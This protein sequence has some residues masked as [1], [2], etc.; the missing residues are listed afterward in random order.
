LAPKAAAELV[1]G[2]VIV[3][4]VFAHVSIGQSYTSVETV[5]QQ[6]PAQTAEPIQREQR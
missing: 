4:A 2:T 5:Q 3:I 1:A 6:I